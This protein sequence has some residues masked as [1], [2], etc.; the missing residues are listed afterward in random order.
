MIRTSLIATL[1]IV[2]IASTALAQIPAVWQGGSGDWDS[3]NWT[4]GG[5]PGQDLQAVAGDN[6]TGYD[7]DLSSL[8]AGQTLVRDNAGTD[9]GQLV[10]TDS[11]FTQSSGLL[12]ITET[13]NSTSSVNVQGAAGVG[14]TVNLSGTAAWELNLIS[15]ANTQ[16]GFRGIEGVLNMSD[17]ASITGLPGNG[18]EVQDGFTV[19]ISGNATIDAGFL[20]FGTANSSNAFVN[21]NGGTI[22]GRTP[23]PI[24]SAGSAGS[25][26]ASNRL[27]FTGATG[28]QQFISTDASDVVNNISAKVTAQVG[29]FAIDGVVVR[30]IGT[31]FV[32]GRGFRLEA[33]PG[34]D[35]GERL[36]TVAQ[37]ANSFVY[38][39]GVDGNWNDAA[40]WNNGLTAAPN[41]TSAGIVFNG[42]FSPNNVDGENPVVSLTTSRSAGSIYLS[43][44]NVTLDAAAGTTL[45]VAGAITQNAGDNQNRTITFGGAGN[46][47]ATGGSS[48]RVGITKT[49]TGTMTLANGL[50]TGTTTVSG[51]TLTVTGSALRS[52]LIDV[53]AGGT[54]N[55][56]GI[57][58][59]EVP[60][61]AAG[62]AFS[63]AGTIQGGLKIFDDSSVAPGDGGVGTL[64]INGPFTLE[65]FNAN[66]TSP[67][68]AGRFTFE[69]GDDNGVVGGGEN[70][71]IQVGGAF[72]TQGFFDAADGLAFRIVPVEGALEAGN[73]T[74]ISHTG[75][76]ASLTGIR[77]LVTNSRGG[78]I[79]NT[80]QSFALNSVA[81]A[82]RLG[83]TGS[84]SSLTWSGTDGTNPTFWD[85][86]TTSNFNGGSQ[87]FFNLDSVTFD[88]SAASFDVV[89]QTTMQPGGVVFNNSANDYLL[90]GA[91]VNGTIAGDGGITKNGTGLVD[92]RL[93]NLAYT[94]DT[95][96]NAGTLRFSG[97]TTGA[98]A[99]ISGDFNVASGAT[100]QISGRFGPSSG[101]YNIAAGG[102]LLYSESS[103]D[104]GAPSAIAD[105][106]Q[107]VWSNDG[108]IIYDLGAQE[109]GFAGV[110]T[111]SGSFTVNSGVAVLSNPGNDF[112]GG[113]QV[114]AGTLSVGQV[115]GVGAQLGTGDVVVEAAGTVL[116]SGRSHTIANNFALNGGTFRVGGGTASAFTSSGTISVGNADSRI[117]LDGDTNTPTTVGYTHTGNIAGT[118]GNDLTVDVA[119]NSTA[120]F[121]GNIG[122]DGALIKTGVGTLALAGAGSISSP[123]IEGRQGVLDV[124]GTTSGSYALASGQTLQVG[125]V[126]FTGTSS[127]V[128]HWTFDTDG[129]DIA[130]GRNN[131]AIFGPS[132]GID[133]T[134]SIAG[135][136][137]VELTNL[138]D[139]DGNRV[140]LPTGGP[141]GG[142]AR[143]YSLW[144][145]G[146]DQTA[147]ELNGTFL[148]AGNNTNGQRFD[149]KVNGTAGNG[150]VGS[151]RTEIQGDFYVFDEPTDPAAYAAVNGVWNH[152][153]VVVDPTISPGD[154]VTTLADVR[155]YFNG[156]ELSPGM[157]GNGSNQIINTLGPDLF[158]G[159]STNVAADR[160]FAGNIDDVQVYDIALSASQIAQLFANPGTSVP[161]PVSFDPQQ[162]TV[163]GDLIMNS[164]SVLAMDL[165]DT[166]A[167]K[168]VVDGTFTAGGTLQVSEFG[169]NNFTLGQT[170]DLLDFNSASGSFASIMLPTIGGG[171]GFDTSQL[172][173]TGEI[174]VVMATAL[175]GDFNGDG[176]VDAADYT[177]WRDNLGAA[178]ESAFAPGTGNGGGIDATDYSLWRTNF[179]TTAGSLVGAGQGA[180]PEPATVVLALAAGLG[181]VV[182]VRR[183]ATRRRN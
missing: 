44:T 48:G 169:T 155:F 99:S 164:G 178:N 163:V 56:A 117:Q 10:L 102:T 41:A 114:N 129:T 19:N 125:T 105:N 70:D 4:V 135:G 107:I 160:N 106:N 71:L 24:R 172:L 91:S 14:S 103:V 158:L 43:H 170:F 58:G 88:D 92:L 87:T 101:N 47:S 69:L 62:Q 65:G 175:A 176:I 81:G 150:P 165:T 42:G 26:F 119:N 133:N 93:D 7:I 50:H 34:P 52:G 75:G 154:G 82:V 112:T 59:Y 57:A 146:A 21:F 140:T 109:A 123:L 9:G 151:L 74:L 134:Q 36:I 157:S 161:L 173:V 6:V 31:T 17:S 67:F 144:V 76:A 1:C 113:I 37:P 20:Q 148:S 85:I 35:G 80:R 86:N 181:M 22:I 2:F 98:P 63:G 96:V 143:T 90:T 53:Q 78:V 40:N 111:G 120:Q 168:L 132:S 84:A 153:A 156:V 183:K 104:A 126:G 145:L 180:V 122:H 174:S 15:G 147:V 73:Y 29:F 142:A 136:G 3:A 39:A 49:G 72:T 182:A 166:V 116:V 121:S 46:F 131:T 108:E 18:F 100:L 33:N 177:V 167:D 95:N 5:T 38:S 149:I 130:P 152:L 51:G 32:N 128:G 66:S 60:I 77:S 127:L 171:L 137:S 12:A 16:L 27:N 138:A 94:G 139:N 162:F 8:L 28:A 55:I 115:G 25:A 141:Q 30:D 83:V 89:L 68:P 159:D 110:I 118:Q 54:L 61:E 124:S 45:T 64:V 79:D 97:G 13:T 179:G 11:T 23:N